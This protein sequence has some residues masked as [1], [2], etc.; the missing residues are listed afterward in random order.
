VS[1]GEAEQQGG[2]WG[3]LGVGEH[4]EEGVNHADTSAQNRYQTNNIAGFNAGGFDERSGHRF[5]LQAY[6]DGGLVANEGAQFV[7]ELAELVG[8]GALV[9][10]QPALETV[11]REMSCMRKH[12]TPGGGEERATHVILCLTKGW[13][14]SNTGILG[15]DEWASEG[16]VL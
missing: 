14:L 3:H 1:G 13:R 4:G 16:N 2:R 10:E 15:A 9:A 5:G 7:D 6:V 12:G 11:R 8:A